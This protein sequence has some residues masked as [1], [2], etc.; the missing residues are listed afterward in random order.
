MERQSWLSALSDVCADYAKCAFRPNDPVLLVNTT[1]EETTI[2]CKNSPVTSWRVRSEK[3]SRA[4][5]V[6]PLT[7]TSHGRAQ[8]EFAS[9]SVSKP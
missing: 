9:R 5:Q 1:S 8:Q 4:C 6:L 7:E 2:N 3:D